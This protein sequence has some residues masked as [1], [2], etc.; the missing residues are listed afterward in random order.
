MNRRTLTTLLLVLLCIAVAAAG[1]RGKPRTKQRVATKGPAAEVKQTV[2]TPTLAPQAPAPVEAAKEAEKPAPAAEAVQPIQP[3]GPITLLPPAGE[4]Q[5]GAAAE[6]PPAALPGAAPAPAPPTAPG[7]P[8]AQKTPDL[9][10]PEAAAQGPLPTPPS[11]PGQVPASPAAP[12]ALPALPATPGLSPAPTAPAQQ[13]SAASP[14]ALPGALPVAPIPG[15]PSAPQLPTAGVASMAAPGVTPPEAAALPAAAQQVP[16]APQLV[17][18]RTDIDILIDASGSMAAPF[19]TGAAAKLDLVRNALYD[20]ILEMGRQQT[21]FPRNIAVRAFGNQSPAAD[22]N[23]QDTQ[24][25]IGMGAPDLSGIRGV[26]DILPAQGLSPLAL[27]LTEAANDFP[28]DTG[29]DRVIVLIADG[30]DNT[31]GDPCAAVATRLEAG[32]VKTTVHVV[33]F[34]VSPNDL[35]QLQCIAE[36]GD[37]K[38]F[39]ARNEGELRAALDQAIN[40]TIPYNLKLLVQAGATPIPFSMTT[41]KGGTEQV[42]RRDKS[43]GSKLVLLPPGTYDFLVEYTDSPERKKPSKILKGV[44]ILQTTK[45]EQTIAFD[46]GQLTLSA[47]GGDGAPA[48]ARYSIAKAGMADPIAEV[49]SGME[50]AVLFLTPG[51]YDITAELLESQIEGFILAEKGV[52]VESAAATERTFLFQKGSLSLKGIT[53]QKEAIPFVFQAFKADRAD[54]LVA[55]GAMP[56]EGGTVLLAP[57][58]YDIIVIGADPKMAAAPRTKI[59]GVEIRAAG[60]TDI[61]AVFEMG[62]MKLAAVDG[63]GGKLPA[64]FVVRDQETQTEMARIVSESGD[65][66]TLPI[67]PG[68]YDIVA[69]SLKSI[70]EPKPAVPVTGVVVTADKPAEQ[71]IKFILGTIKL[72]GR[73]AKEQPINT[74]FTIYRAASDEIVTTAPPSGDWMVFD[75]APGTY[76]ALAT[77]VASEEKPQPMIWLRDIRVGDGQTI[78]HEA[79]F[80]AGKLKIIGRGPNNQIITCNFKVFQY[81]KDRELINGTTGQDWEVFEIQPGKY[82]LEAGYHDDAQ[83]VLLKQWV[84]ISVGENEVV[85]V[86]LRF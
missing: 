80:T 84:N 27:A 49:E 28:P 61:V 45:V 62:T 75:L 51:S 81:G 26:L 50:P 60:T 17:K 70:L 67:P 82:Y 78:S 42:V 57:G 36:K 83:S 54:L 56:A 19:S 46:L 41:T 53:T 21:D 85:E 6:A 16:Y 66:V 2:A 55:S 68:T 65:P 7:A 40:S 13:P 29:A 38:F 76:D 10:Q 24:L 11:A 9:I 44:E 33:A 59:S 43:F 69:S 23:R 58:I 64:Q 12:G 30:A 15:A 8:A 39:L 31:E 63:K 77:N 22:A 72:R 86:V 74:Q 25:I 32:P 79:I 35:E 5:P 37:G 52:V 71:T 20:I 34:D 4:A 14:G 47:T 1:C 3:R 73:N 48:A 18:G